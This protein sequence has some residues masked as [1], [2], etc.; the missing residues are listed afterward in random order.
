MSAI[1]LCQGKDRSWKV[2]QNKIQNSNKKDKH[3][4]KIKTLLLLNSKNVST[5]EII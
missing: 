4:I 3:K 2:K 1:R 5:E